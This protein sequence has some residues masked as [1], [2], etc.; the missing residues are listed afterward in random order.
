MSA[1]GSTPSAIS[2]SRTAAARRSDRLWLYAIRPE[3]AC[4]T[5]D[6]D[7]PDATMLETVQQRPQLRLARVR[8]HGRVVRKQCPP[9]QLDL[10]ALDSRHLALDRLRSLHRYRSI[11]FGRPE[12][13]PELV[14]PETVRRACRRALRQR[15][16]RSNGPSLRKCSTS[17]ATLW[18]VPRKYFSAPTMKLS[19]S[20]WPV[21]SSAS[22]RS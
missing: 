22:P 11:C 4:V 12:R 15:L 20:A 14:A 16:P 2:Q 18:P 5:D 8:Q 10:V 7:L 19:W 17:N 13:A 3:V 6:V 21:C 9:R 1:C